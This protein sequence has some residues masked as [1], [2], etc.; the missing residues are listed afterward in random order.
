MGKFFEKARG[1]KL[2]TENALFGY[3]WARIDVSTLKFV[4]LENFK[5][6]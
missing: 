3:F 6:N 2:G 5:K 4:Y 1:T